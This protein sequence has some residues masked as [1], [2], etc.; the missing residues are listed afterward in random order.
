MEDY[1]LPASLVGM[2]LTAR[3]TGKP[4]VQI[5]LQATK[6]SVMIVLDSATSALKKSKTPP[7]KKKPSTTSTTL[8][9]TKAPPSFYFATKEIS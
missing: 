8:A 4:T 7:A 2:L 3:I 9:K 5:D 1:R 6:L